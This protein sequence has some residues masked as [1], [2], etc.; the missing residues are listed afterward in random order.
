PHRKRMQPD[1]IIVG[2][3]TA[4]SLLAARLSET[5]ANVLLLEAGPDTWHP[6]IHVP[7][8]VRSLHRNPA[9]SWNYSTEPHS[10]TGNRAI[11]WP[12]GRVIGGS[13]S[14][15]G[16]LYVRGNPGD[17]DSWAKMGC[18]GWSYAEVLPYFKKTE[19]YDAGDPHYRG[20]D[21]PLRVVDYKAHLNLTHRFVQ[22]AQQVGVPFTKDYNG[23]QQE[24]VAYAQMTRLGRF[25][26][27]TA[28]ALLRPARSRPN[29]R[30][31]TRALVTRLVFEGNKCVGVTFRKA[32]QD[33]TVRAR[34]EVILCGGA[35]NSPQLLMLSGVGPAKEL[36]VLGIPIVHDAPGVGKNL[37]DHYYGGVSAR[38]RGEVSINQLA[39]GWR[40]LRELLRF[41]SMGDG[42]L[43]YGVTAAPLFTRSRPELTRPDLQVLF[44]P[45]S[46]DR[47]RFGA[48]EVEPGVTAVVCIAQ[49]ESRGSL[50]LRSA[51]PADSPRIQP[52]YL[53]APNDVRTLVAGVR[54]VRK[55]FSAPAMKQC[56]VGETY[57]GAQASSDEAI[58]DALR[59]TG[60]TG[61]HAVGTCRMGSD[62]NAVVDPQ[63]R[64]LGVSGLRVVDASVM[65][66]VPTG[67]TNA[68]T[69]MVAEKGADLIRAS[70][71]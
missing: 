14:I 50:T 15:N 48:L 31:E 18:A 7:A 21:G 41:V 20:K 23:A 63:L 46:Y 26:G 55:I 57:P 71:M 9:L 60:T 6:M 69:A 12:R 19:R 58:A 13:G 59:L 54:L 2:A 1:Y 44:T 62:A 24:G 70:G 29:L 53:S 35:I 38:V 34:R 8:G 10:D 32:A 28:F 4:G 30:V 47:E 67:N 16:M 3:G 52:N 25:R 51:D 49:P 64:V 66:M 36:Q 22:A 17:Y 39:R 11:H 37:I 33:T 45:A 40:L 68:P 42:A 27:S 61:Y 43:T 65:P 5:S 56:M